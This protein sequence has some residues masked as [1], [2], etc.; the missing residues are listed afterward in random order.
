MI[1]LY[2]FQLKIDDKLCANKKLLAHKFRRNSMKNSLTIF[3]I[4]SFGLFSGCTTTQKGAA[5]GG[6]SGATIGGIIGHQSGDGVTGA[7]IGGVIGTVGGLVVGE[8][9]AKKFC[10]E[11]GE[12]FPEDVKF[13]PKHGVELKLKE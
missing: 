11:G 12:T 10:P 1:S 8:K 9:M 5:V 3:F 2:L 6:V 13:C 4:L 7:A